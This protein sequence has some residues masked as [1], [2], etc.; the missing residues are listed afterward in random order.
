MRETSLDVQAQLK[1]LRL[2]G[3]ATAWADLTE[4]GGDTT[5]AYYARLG[6]TVQRLLRQRLGVPLAR[7]Q[8]DLHRACHQAQLHAALPTADQRQGRG[9]LP[10]AQ[11]DFAHGVAELCA[12]VGDQFRSAR[13]RRRRSDPRELWPRA[14]LR[15]KRSWNVATIVLLRHRGAWRTRNQVMG[16]PRYNGEFVYER[17]DPQMWGRTEQAR[18]IDPARPEVDLLT[19]CAK[20]RSFRRER[21]AVCQRHG[22]LPSRRE[23]QARR[24][25]SAVVVHVRPGARVGRAGAHGCAQLDRL[26]YHFR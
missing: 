19:C 17:A 21:A 9:E 5:L 7:V 18:L 24:S 11:L 4:Q 12:A 8:G 2:N 16:Q 6:V 1:A 14:V 25:P 13:R 22:L 10:R 26:P 3:M 20:R 15:R 23:E